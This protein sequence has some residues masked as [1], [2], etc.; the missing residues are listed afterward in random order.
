MLTDNQPTSGEGKTNLVALLNEKLARASVLVDAGDCDNAIA[1]LREAIEFDS[2]RDL[3]WFKLGEAYRR[4]QK[5]QEAR[6]AYSE[7]IAI[8]PIGPY[9]NNLGET[10]HKLGNSSEAISAYRN[11]ARVDPA[12]A[13]TYYFNVGAV[14]TNTGNLEDA[15]EAYD[16]AIWANPK[17]AS[18]HYFKGVN[19][20]GEARTVCGEVTVPDGAIEAFHTYLDLQPDGKFAATALQFIA[21][22]GN[23]IVTIYTR[24]WSPTPLNSVNRRVRK[25]AGAVSERKD[26]GLFLRRIYPSY[27]AL[28]KSAR[29]QGPAVLNAIIGEDGTVV[30]VGVVSGNPLLLESSIDAVRQWK[31]KPFVIDDQAVEVAT[32]VRIIFSLSENTSGKLAPQ[33]RL[34]RW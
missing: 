16:E 33:D 5:Y 22:L 4:A 2:S 12:N 19:L 32:E 29:V 6:A 26:Q 27:P 20:L 30:F 7:A 31:Y 34:S 8:K 10:H 1:V 24:D 21:F 17:H 15:N 11:A 14:H 13:S 25:S 23:R 18:A 28:A 3:L 9:Y